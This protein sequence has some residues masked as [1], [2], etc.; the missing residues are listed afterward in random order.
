VYLEVVGSVSC[1]GEPARYV[2]F[3]Q[4]LELDAGIQVLNEH[5]TKIAARAAFTT[6]STNV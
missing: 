3:A 5:V 2:H 6:M 4:V 1:P